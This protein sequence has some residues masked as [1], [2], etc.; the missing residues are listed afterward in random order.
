M[1]L[2]LDRIRPNADT[3]GNNMTRWF[4]LARW[5]AWSLPIVMLLMGN[6]LIAQPTPTSHRES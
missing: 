2:S 6:G 1:L 3:G 5:V 4:S